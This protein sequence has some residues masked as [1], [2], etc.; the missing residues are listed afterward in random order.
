MTENGNLQNLLTQARVALEK[1]EETGRDIIRRSEALQAE[2][3]QSRLRRE[4]L[5]GQVGALEAAMKNEAPQPVQGE[6]VPAGPPSD[7]VYV[8]PE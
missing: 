8:N 1:E 2:A 6:V 5:S 7:A 4:N 3:A